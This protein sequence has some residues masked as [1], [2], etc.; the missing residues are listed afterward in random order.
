MMRSKA[1]DVR[2]FDATGLSETAERAVDGAAA[3]FSD[4]KLP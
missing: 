1:L 3:G 4:V 2:A